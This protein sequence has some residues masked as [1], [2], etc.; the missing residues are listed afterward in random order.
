VDAA[1]T[2]KLTTNARFARSNT[3]DAARSDG[4]I[5]MPPWLP[6]TA[7]AIIAASGGLGFILQLRLV[8]DK[9]RRKRTDERG[10]AR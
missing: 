9:L 10:A 2:A 6:L 7:L 4:H 1:P 3:V 5:R 8:L